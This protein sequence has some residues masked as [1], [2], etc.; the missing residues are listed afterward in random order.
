MT[1]R[2]STKVLILIRLILIRLLDPDPLARRMPRRTR[3]PRR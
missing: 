3:P 1:G 2:L